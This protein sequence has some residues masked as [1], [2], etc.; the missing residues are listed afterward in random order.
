MHV[1]VGL[2]VA[3][4]VDQSP[5]SLAREH[6]DRRSQ[7]IGPDRRELDAR[8][9][10]ELQSVARDDH[11]RLARTGDS[12]RGRLEHDLGA[13]L[14]LR[15]MSRHARR[16]DARG[17]IGGRQVDLEV[18]AVLRRAPRAAPVEHLLAAAGLDREHVGDHRRRH[19]GVR[20]AQP[21]GLGALGL[22]RLAGEAHL[23]LVG[24]AQ[25][26]IGVPVD[27]ERHPVRVQALLRGALDVAAVVAVGVGGAD[28][29]V[30]VLEHGGQGVP[31]R[32]GRRRDPDLVGAEGHHHHLSLVALVGLPQLAHP[33]RR[34]AHRALPPA[35]LRGRAAPAP[36][37]I[38]RHGGQRGRRRRAR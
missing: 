17:E 20:L 6:G 25:E 13:R 7:G 36:P 34:L 31:R 10:A 4:Q 14:R 2:P 24:R 5:R 29:V 32:R 1:A 9:R 11:V 22:R 28:L 35:P 15:A 21:H 18:H 30:V 33:R 38:S 37:I 27:V 8:P 3:L 12:H 23:A 19:V 26:R 16:V